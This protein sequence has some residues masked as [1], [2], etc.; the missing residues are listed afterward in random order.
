MNKKVVWLVMLVLLVST[1]AEAQQPAKVHRI[2]MLISGSALTHKSYIDAFRRGLRD[3]GYV[4]GKNVLIEYRYGE[5]QRERY[6]ALAAE[7]VR[8]K[9]EVIVV[10]SVGFTEAVKQATS[11]IPIV[12]GGAGDLVGT[13]LVASLARPGGNVTGSTNISSDLSGKR[14]ELLKE[15]VPKVS[16]VAVLLYPVGSD[17]DELKQT[18]VAAQALKVKIQVVPVKD[19]SEFQSAYAAMRRENA[20]ALILIQGSFT[21]FHRKELIESGT[22]NLLPTMCEE[23]RWTE[24][25]GLMSYGPDLIYQWNRAAVFMDKILKGAKPADPPVEQPTKFELVIN[26]KTAKQI[27]VTIAPNVLARADKVIK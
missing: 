3:L 2:G 23:L 14:L 4:E 18:E 19:P 21:A 17:L 6:P 1:F 26:L 20:N 12:V 13:G 27:G 16:R 25:G 5:G 10:G 15:T 7:M 24:D 11:T 8:L 9:P 22:K